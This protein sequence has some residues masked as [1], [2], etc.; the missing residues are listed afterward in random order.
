MQDSALINSTTCHS[1]YRCPTRFYWILQNKTWNI[2][3]LQI[4][5]NP[6]LSKIEEC[7]Y[8][9][10]ISAFSSIDLKLISYLSFSGLWLHYQVCRFLYCSKLHNTIRMVKKR[11]ISVVCYNP[12]VQTTLKMLRIVFETFTIKSRIYRCVLPI[13]GWVYLLC[14]CKYQS[15]WNPGICRTYMQLFSHLR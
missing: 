4:S 3:K 13:L 5:I 15:P 8:E 6:N 10:G 11:R 1:F 7:C 9:T 2:N 12:I 14:F